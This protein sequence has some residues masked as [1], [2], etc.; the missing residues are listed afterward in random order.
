MSLL[1]KE[2]IAAGDTGAVALRGD[3]VAVTYGQLPHEI[4]QRA[5]QL[6]GLTCAALAED[7]GVPWVLWDLAA[8]TAG[9]T[10]VPIPPFFTPAQRDHALQSAG[11]Q[12]LITAQGIIPLPQHPPRLP[13]GTAKIT[14]TSG[15][16]GTPRGVC[17][18]ESAM[19]ATARAITGRLGGL[20]SGG[21][22]VCVLPL[23]VLLENVAG[24]YA[25]LLSGGTVELPSLHDIG[26]RHENLRA[27]INAAD[28]HSVILVPELLRLLMA[29]VMD[30]GPLPS[31]RFAAVGG[32]KVAADLIAAARNAGLPAY[33]GY[34]LSECGSVVSLNTPD[35]DRYGTCGRLLPHV[36]AHEESGEIIIDNPGFLGYVG[37][38][39]SG[40]FATGDIGAIDDGFLS[41]TGRR[42]NILITSYGRNVSP[43]WV[44][45]QLL[46][47]PEIMQA[48]VHGDAQAHLSAL[49]VPSFAGADIAAAVRR[50]NEGLPDYARV[51]DIRIV[52][53]F[54]VQ[55]GMLTGTGRP[56][57]NIILTHFEKEK[58]M[59]F[60]DRLIKETES[61]RREL[62]TVPQLVDGLKGD[63][64][65]E[66]YIAYLTEAYHHVRHTVRFLMA[67]GARLPD[68]KKWLH[69]AISEYI[70]EEK[71]HEEW[72][73]N[74]IAAAGAD[75]EK[76]RAATPNLETQVL[77]AYNYDYIA[78]KNPVGFLGMVFMLESTSTQIAN[79]GADAVRERL[80]LPKSAF[81]YLYSHGALDIE[82][83]KF[84]EKTVNRVT[85]PADQAAII[86]VANNAFR[87][88]ANVMRAIPHK[89]ESRH[90]A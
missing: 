1:V 69:D 23:A 5:A 90:A 79:N 12:A 44:E 43:E 20:L 10:L 6:R 27:R 37:A 51:T 39:H 2:I 49:I 14:F 7:N 28:A 52:P 33:E 45:S 77:V 30:Q 19:L 48:V 13:A 72:I 78:R 59:N 68:D 75:K 89:Q 86:E 54:T 85:E 47:Q 70:E 22:H 57:R 55:N 29:Q 21:T 76:A 46:L 34:G 36:T 60:Y 50:A 35:D 9:V 42:K 16:T 18:S 25:A 11:C 84:F 66:T 8:L 26:A 82:H 3:G 87:L 58:T 61:A 73:L 32:S 40:P 4:A 31:L 56:R 41:I 65:R 62:Y 38:P 64:N 83:M 74:D 67:M 17:L 24:V 71:G 81:T 80:G 63:I 88:F 15:T 53:P